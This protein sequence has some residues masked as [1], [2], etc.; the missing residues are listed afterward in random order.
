MANRIVTF[1]AEQAVRQPVA[2][3]LRIGNSG[4]R[5]S[6]ELPFRRVVDDA[7]RLRHRTSHLMGGETRGGAA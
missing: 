2:R 7:S 1:P 4:L 5:A 6:D 3:F